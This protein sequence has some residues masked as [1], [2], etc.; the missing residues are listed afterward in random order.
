MMASVYMVNNKYYD[1]KKILLEMLDMPGVDLFN[2]YSFLVVNEHNLLSERSFFFYGLDGDAQKYNLKLVELL[3]K[4]GKINYDKIEM[5]INT[6]MISFQN[7][8]DKAVEII[9]SILDKIDDVK[10]K[11]KYEK[12]LHIMKERNIITRLDEDDR[13][14][15]CISNIIKAHFDLSRVDD[16]EE[17]TWLEISL[18]ENELSVIQNYRKYQKQFN[19]LQ[20]EYKMLYDVIENFINKIQ[21][22]KSRN[23]LKKELDKKVKNQEISKF[24]EFMSGWR[25][26]FDDNEYDDDYSYDEIIEQHVR[27]EAKIGRNDKCPCGSGKK[28]KNCCMNK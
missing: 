14:S 15:E 2:V 4:N 1:V 19:I 3:E 11:N 8:P 5:V 9:Q 27:D 13:I 12:S 24:N 22:T 18:A 26:G 20:K 25:N 10:I 7:K 21:F 17:I 28:Y 6:I 16:Y 23:K